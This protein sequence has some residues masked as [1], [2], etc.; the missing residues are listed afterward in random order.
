M[1]M[2][3]NYKR[4]FDA[5]SM[6]P[7]HRE[8]IRAALSSRIFER[9]KEN[10]IMST[11]TLFGRRPGSVAVAAII[12]LSAALFAGFTYGSQIIQ[13]FGGGLIEFGVDSGGNQYSSVESFVSDPVE[14]RDGQ[15][16][17][18]LDGSGT[19]ITGYCTEETYYLYERV[20]DS[21]YRHAVL[22]GGTPDNLGWAEFVWDENGGFVGGNAMRNADDIPVWLMRGQE[23]LGHKII[24]E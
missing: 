1:V 24:T 16:Y 15:V 4:T 14:L 11:K 3:Y 19:N 5:V 22:I 8:Q 9:Q 21:G 23:T 20:D 13:L 18:V 6:P 10:N 2:K 17:F 12:V 7:E